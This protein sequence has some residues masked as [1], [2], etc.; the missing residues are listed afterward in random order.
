[1]RK[2]LAYLLVLL[3]LGVCLCAGASADS[4]TDYSPDAVIQF[5][6]RWNAWFEKNEPLITCGYILSDDGKTV[7]HICVTYNSEN[8]HVGY[9]LEEI[10]DTADLFFLYNAADDD[11]GFCVFSDEMDADL[12]KVVIYLDD[13]AISDAFTGSS[14]D[15]RD[16]WS[17]T[18]STDDLI[19]VLSVDSFTVRMT[20]NGKNRILD[21]SQ[22]DQPYLYDMVFWLLKAQLYSDASYETYLSAEYLPEDSASAGPAQQSGSEDVTGTYSFREDY[23]SVDN[24]AKSLFYVETYD[25]KGLSIGTASGFVSFDEHLFV[26]NQ[27]VIEGASYLRIW[28]DDDNVYMIDKVVASD[29]EHDIAILLFPEGVNYTALEQDSE[30]ELLR[31]QPIVTIGSPQGFQNTVAYGNISA[32]PVIDGIQYIQFTAPISHG[33][34]GGCLFDDDGKVIGI[35]SA[36]Y[37]DG[38]NLN[39][40]IPIGLVQDLYAGWDKTSYEVLGTERS[41]DMA[42]ITPEPTRTPVPDVTPRPGTT[43]EN[44]F[45]LGYLGLLGVDDNKAESIEG[46]WELTDA[47]SESDGDFSGAVVRMKA[48]GGVVRLTFADGLMTMY[49]DLPGEDVTEESTTYVFRDGELILEGTTLDGVIED[50][51]L[52]LTSEGNTLIFERQE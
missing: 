29:K 28:D 40:A 10:P 30:K 23:K 48:L 27:H 46:V 38:Q 20:V 49:M 41:W 17:V 22:A 4:V 51:K 45:V 31:G 11:Y 2:A 44:D 25:K 15:P 12:E 14:H 42:S 36:G 8:R 26:T 32:F 37:E 33:S 16:M 24:A 43:D 39:F 52:I 50:G 34:S 6:D 21:V 19:S 3:L 1:M 18:L 13:G 9:S 7:E 35:T 47:K 5:C